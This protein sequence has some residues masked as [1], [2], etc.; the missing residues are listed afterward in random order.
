MVSIG[1][2]DN[3]SV[4]VFREKIDFKIGNSHHVA[5]RAFKL[6]A[7]PI[8]ASL[9]YVRDNVT[10]RLRLRMF[11]NQYKSDLTPR[12]GF[13]HLSRG[14]SMDRD[15]HPALLLGAI[16]IHGIT[17]LDFSIDCRYLYMYL[18]FARDERH[19]CELST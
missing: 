2:T 11:F 15:S 19:L 7:Q 3:S 5:I 9:R 4:I 17:R 14:I 13:Q 6:S 12:V 1:Y 16:N 10:H 8:A 18:T